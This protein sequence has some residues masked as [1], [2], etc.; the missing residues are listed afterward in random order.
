[1]STLSLHSSDL[2]ITI[3]PN[4]L[5]FSDTSELLQHPLSWIGQERAELATRFGL[6]M[7]QPDYHL[8]VPN[9][10]QPADRRPGADGLARQLGLRPIHGA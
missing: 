9:C 2:R 6:G 5:G 7:L 3:D 1:M 8:F 10:G 4:S